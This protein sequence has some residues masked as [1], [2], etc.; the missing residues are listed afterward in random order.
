MAAPVP[1]KS[2]S[3]LLFDEPSMYSEKNT[4]DGAAVAVPGT[5]PITATVA[6][7]AVAAA[8]PRRTNG[9]TNG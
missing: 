6:A 4:S 7:T 5:S 1:L 8:I 2:S 9:R 3:A